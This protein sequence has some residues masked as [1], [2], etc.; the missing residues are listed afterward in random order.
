MSNASVSKILTRQARSLEALL[1]RVDAQQS[2]V[3]AALTKV[4][5]ALDSAGDALSDKP[6]A[7]AK[8]VRTA[9]TKEAATPVSKKAKTATPIEEP[10]TRRERREARAAAAAKKA[11]R[12]TAPV[13]ST[14]SKKAAVEAPA[15]KSIGLKKTAK[16]SGLKK[17]PVEAK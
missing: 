3:T 13:A 2:V 17:A 4:K 5:E 12:G 6:T 10:M 11:T 14:K 15:K 9:K 8:T 16:T 1:K 7:P